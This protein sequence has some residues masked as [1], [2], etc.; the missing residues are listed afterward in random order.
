MAKLLNKVFPNRGLSS[1][2]KEIKHAEREVW[3]DRNTTLA[4]SFSPHDGEYE[5][6]RRFD[7]KGKG[8]KG[9]CYRAVMRL[10]FSPA[11]DFGWIIVGV[12]S[13][14]LKVR[15]IEG[16]EPRKIVIDDGRI[17]PNGKFYWT[18]TRNKLQHLVVGKYCKSVWCLMQDKHN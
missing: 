9:S 18:E 11:P 14:R 15:G 7:H 12:G 13:E 5:Y 16:G 3:K 4:P 8:H 1:W 6:T 17:A 2:E 10:R